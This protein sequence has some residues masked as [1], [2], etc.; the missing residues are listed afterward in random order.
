MTS[1]LNF[2]KSKASSARGALFVVIGTIALPTQA[3]IVPDATLP[4]PSAIAGDAT[5]RSIVGGTQAG[6]N[7]FHS[8]AEFNIQPDE[9]VSFEAASSVTD[10]FARVTGANASAIEGTLSSGANLFLLNPNGISWGT[11]ARADVAGALTLST[12]D[13]VLFA[14]GSRWDLETPPD[15]Q[16]LTISAPIGLGLPDRGTLSITGELAIPAEET[17]RLAS[18]TIAIAGAQVSAPGG[19]SE[20]HT[21]EL[22]SPDHLVCRLLLEKKKQNNNKQTNKTQTTP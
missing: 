13:S 20:E 8:F 4:E 19:R 10:I 21:S 16:L 5:N 15:R 1:L 22:Q 7:L 18:P 17:L 14:D 11:T 9:R 3:Q 2:A 6:T 12:A